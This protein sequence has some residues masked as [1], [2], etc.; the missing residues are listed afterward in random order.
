MIEKLGGKIERPQS[1][2]K[3]SEKIQA[4]IKQHVIPYLR[5]EED[6]NILNHLIKIEDEVLFSTFDVFESDRDEEEL[7]DTVIRIINKHKQ[8]KP[9]EVPKITVEQT[10]SVK[11]D[12]PKKEEKEKKAHE[13][14]PTK[15]T[16]QEPSKLIPEPVKEEPKVPAKKNPA[17]GTSANK[18]K[19]TAAPNKLVQPDLSKA[20]PIKK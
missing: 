17:N 18:E 20:E 12:R 8:K 19:A 14:L 15:Q 6:I 7:V 13:P 10:T 5:D 1:P 2:Y 11:E 16:K 3:K 9:A 4:L